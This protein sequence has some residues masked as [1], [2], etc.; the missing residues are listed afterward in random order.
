[1]RLP[2]STGIIPSNNLHE[3]VERTRIV[4]ELHRRKLMAI[5]EVTITR[6]EEEGCCWTLIG[7]WAATVLLET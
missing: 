2:P 4:T 1:M 6:P 3:L 5:G 7:T